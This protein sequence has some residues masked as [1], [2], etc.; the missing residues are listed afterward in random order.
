MSVLSTNVF[1]GEN[2]VKKW[3]ENSTGNLRTLRSAFQIDAQKQF[4]NLC[5]QFGVKPQEIRQ[6]AEEKTLS[7]IVPLRDEKFVC[8]LQTDWLVDK[9]GAEALEEI[10]LQGY[11]SY[12]ALNFVDGHRSILDI[13]QA[14]SAEFGPVELQDVL[15]F[16]RVLERAGLVTLK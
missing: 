4:K 8:P 12:E 9:L 7:R 11:A 14:V 3:I 16:F 15:A 1:A 2:Q 5:Q 10:K 6:S 13:K